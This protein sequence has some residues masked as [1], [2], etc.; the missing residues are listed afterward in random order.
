MGNREVIEYPDHLCGCIVD[1]R[2]TDRVCNSLAA[3]GCDPIL[4]SARPGMKGYWESTGFAP[5]FLTDYDD[6]PAWHQDDGTCT[7]QGTGHA[8]QTSIRALIKSGNRIG[9]MIELAWEPLYILARTVTGRAGGRVGAGI[10]QA[11]EAAYRFGLLQRGK[12]SVDLTSPQEDWAVQMSQW[13]SHPLP[14][15][16]MRAMANYRLAAGMRVTSLDMAADALA[17]KYCL[18]RGGDR[19]TGA[20]RNAD[21]ITRTVQCGSHCEHLCL[22]FKDR[23]GKRVWGERQSWR[24]TPSQPHG[25]ATFKL[26]DGSER[27]VPDGVGGLYDEDVQYYIDYGDLWTAEPPET[28]WPENEVA[29]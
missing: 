21:G 12:W 16:M 23:S 7:G 15:D 20:V 26:F 18:I 11:I 10:P 27:P 4:E 25:N 8:I 6:D 13:G 22:V 5:V 17:A 2:E 28:L 3:A 24:G 29:A 9:R 1:Q 19:A 14:A